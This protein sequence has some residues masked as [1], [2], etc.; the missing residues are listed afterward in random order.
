MG[1]EGED[2]LIQEEREDRGQPSPAL[3]PLI[4]NIGAVM[5]LLTNLLAG[6]QEQQVAQRQLQMMQT[7]ALSTAL[8]E[9][10]DNWI[11]AINV[12]AR[13]GAWNDGIKLNMEKAALRGEAARWRPNGFVENEWETWSRAL[14]EAFRKQYTLQEWFQLVKERQQEIGESAARYALEKSKLDR[15]FS[16]GLIQNPPQTIQEFVATYGKLKKPYFAPPLW[17]LCLTV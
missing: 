4:Q 6:Q 7:E 14:A 17:D 2:P 9:K 12:E 5:L 8:Q 13:A 16:P 15:Q 3:S 1:H 11:H 10:V